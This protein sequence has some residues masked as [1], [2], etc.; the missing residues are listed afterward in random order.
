MN[1]GHCNCSSEQEAQELR[2]EL[3]V[4]EF[5]IQEQRNEAENTVVE[6]FYENDELLE[7]GKEIQ[8]L[9]AL[10]RSIDYIIKYGTLTE[11][12]K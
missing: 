2:L 12:R 11:D 7:R 6:T 4:L 9:S 3:H 1:K 8:S 10:K 5:V